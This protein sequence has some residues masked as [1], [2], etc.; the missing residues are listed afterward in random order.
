[1]GNHATS[2]L[3][4]AMGNRDLSAAKQIL[5]DAGQGSGDLIDEDYTSDCMFNCTRNVQV[6]TMKN[7]LC[8]S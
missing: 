8:I 1:M 4:R 7:T 2:P 3:R 5:D 6:I